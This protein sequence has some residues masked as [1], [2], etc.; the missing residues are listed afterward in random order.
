MP[1]TALGLSQATGSVSIS[2]HTEGTGLSPVWHEELYQRLP[3]P[4]PHTWARPPKRDCLWPEVHPGLSPTGSVSGW[5]SPG[6]RPGPVHFCGLPARHP[7]G[8]STS[9]CRAWQRAGWRCL[10]AFPTAAPGGAG[11]GPPLPL[12]SAPVRVAAQTG[13]GSGLCPMSSVRGR[14]GRAQLWGQCSPHMSL[15]GANGTQNTDV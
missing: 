13:W 7:F 8:N 6:G 3:T 2:T 15:S 5:Q 12:L 10:G 11:G 4:P 1:G 9:W 14:L